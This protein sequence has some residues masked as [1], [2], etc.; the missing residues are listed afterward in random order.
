MEKFL[1]GEVTLFVLEAIQASVTTAQELA[2]VFA[3]YS[4]RY[5]SSLSFRA[6]NWRPPKH[7]TILT[8]QIAALKE[9]QKMCKLIY[10]L[11]SEGFVVSGTNK[12][13]GVTNK[14]EDH[15]QIIRE[16]LSCRRRYAYVGVDV[17]KI[18]VFD[19][20]ETKRASR[21]WLRDVLKS[22]KF[23]MVQKSVWAGKSKVPEE[24]FDDL[25]L[26]GL[27]DYVE[28]FAVTKTGTLKQIQ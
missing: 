16:R 15:A 7:G 9:K 27:L 21:R 11:K 23:F 26:K 5:S 10:K 2:D 25:R 24:F 28:I 19:I 14:G 17:F 8:K 18:I 4:K 12:A 6:I 3:Y 20:P 13:L 1:R 22:L